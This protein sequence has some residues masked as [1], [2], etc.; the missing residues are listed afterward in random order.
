[1][2]NEALPDTDLDDL[3]DGALDD[4][5]DD[6]SDADLQSKKD[7]SEVDQPL[8]LKGSSTAVVD[9][10]ASLLKM[11]IHGKKDELQRMVSE[12]ETRNEEMR[13]AV[14]AAAKAKHQ[15]KIIEMESESD[16]EDASE[17]LTPSNDLD[18]PDRA[19]SLVTQS[20]DIISGGF[21]ALSATELVNAPS[22]LRAVRQLLRFTP[23]YRILEESDMKAGVTP[24]SRVGFLPLKGKKALMLDGDIPRADAISITNP[25]SCFPD[26]DDRDT[27]VTEFMTQS[28][29]IKLKN[30]SVKDGMFRQTK[31]DD[32][33]ILITD[34]HTYLLLNSEF[35]PG[36][37]H[38]HRKAST[39]AGKI[40]GYVYYPYSDSPETSFVSG[41]GEANGAHT[42]KLMLAFSGGRDLIAQVVQR[43]NGGMLSTRE[44]DDHVNDLISEICQDNIANL[45]NKNRESENSEIEDFRTSVDDNERLVASIVNGNATGITT[46]DHSRAVVSS[47]RKKTA[48]VSV[49]LHHMINDASSIDMSGDQMTLTSRVKLSADNDIGKT[50]STTTVTLDKNRPDLAEAITD[51][52]ASIDNMA[53]LQTTDKD[54]RLPLEWSLIESAQCHVLYLSK[55]LTHA[56]YALRNLNAIKE[57]VEQ[58]GVNAVI[59]R[60]KQTYTIS[61]SENDM[62]QSLQASVKEAVEALTTT[63]IDLGRHILASDSANNIKAYPYTVLLESQIA[64]EGLGHIMG[65]P[66]ESCAVITNTGEENGHITATSILDALSVI[67]LDSENRISTPPIVEAI[68]SAL[69]TEPVVGDGVSPTPSIAT[70]HQ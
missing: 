35:L 38:S 54:A 15:T 61:R 28:E 69:P 16:E 39:N 42:S 33:E 25:E 10:G 68:L 62:S 60:S 11:F 47:D 43:D 45:T 21:K 40:S 13:R 23:T 34:T 17:D 8:K 44:V 56:A 14:E 29:A 55:C 53:R 41:A 57:G 46:T 20:V 1:M 50:S 58:H 27:A 22:F 66:P 3:L 4:I 2:T 30:F 64:R 19:M 52:I 65:L 9:D 5:S 26:I 63:A 48:M 59:K 70:P 51:C 37:G 18:I 67:R 32:V 49:I 7:G 12:V 36:D 31:F 6:E 24:M